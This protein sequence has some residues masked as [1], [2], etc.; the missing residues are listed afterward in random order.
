MCCVEILGAWVS[1]NPK[2][3]SRH[4]V[5]YLYLYFTSGKPPKTVLLKKYAFWI[6]N[7]TLQRIIK[8]EGITVSRAGQHVAVGV[9]D[10]N[11]KTAVFLYFGLYTSYLLAFQRWVLKQVAYKLGTRLCRDWIVLQQDVIYVMQYEMNQMQQILGA[12]AELRRTLFIFVMFVCLSVFPCLSALVEQ[13]GS[14][15][16]DF[17]EIFIW[18]LF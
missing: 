18:M 5:G 4:V 17:Y 13:L 6:S 2:G 3:L 11:C 1:W 12:F 14:Y 10:K 9:F 7:L 8:S 16:T 15:W